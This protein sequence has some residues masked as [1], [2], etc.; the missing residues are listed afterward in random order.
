[1]RRVLRPGGRLGVAVWSV[2]EKV[3]LFLISRLVGAALPPPPGDA[4]P[5]PMAMGAPG[6]IEGL[7][8]EAGFRD[9]TVARVTRTFEIADPE[10]EWRRT[11]E[12][13]GSPAARGLTSLSP[14][15]RQ[16]VHDEAIAALEQ[17]RAGDTLHIPSEAVLVRATK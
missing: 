5:S 7:V 4:P 16:R 11:A 12:N 9:V 10:A 1:M 2:P 15:A 6:I 13:P 17:F 14:A 3:G 8:E